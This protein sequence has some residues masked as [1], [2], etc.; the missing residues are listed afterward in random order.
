ME[1]S[2]DSTSEVKKRGAELVK[3]SE[4]GGWEVALPVVA[5]ETYQIKTK[6]ITTF[7]GGELLL[8]V[9]VLQ[10]KTLN[11]TLSLTPEID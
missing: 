9:F 7:E 4:G 8:D 5:Y 6:S 3:S 2:G 11:L 10:I 1:T